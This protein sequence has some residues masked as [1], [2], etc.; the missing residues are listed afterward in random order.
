[1]TDELKLDFK[2]LDTDGA[3]EEA[4]DRVETHTRGDFMKKRPRR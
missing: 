3:L 4:A 1:M 2:L